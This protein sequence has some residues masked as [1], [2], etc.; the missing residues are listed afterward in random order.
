MPVVKDAALVTRYA[1]LRYATLRYAK[2]LKKSVTIK[3]MYDE[4]ANIIV[5]CNVA[6]D[7]YD[8]WYFR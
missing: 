3:H 8:S 4:S 1:T 6:F 7:A 2:S 5:G